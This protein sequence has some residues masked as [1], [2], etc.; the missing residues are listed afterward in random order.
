[1]RFEGRGSDEL[2]SGGIK[3][4]NFAVYKIKTIKIMLLEFHNGKFNITDIKFGEHLIEASN[5]TILYYGILSR[6]VTEKQLKDALTSNPN[7]KSLEDFFN[8][9]YF[10]NN[11]TN[12]AA[13]P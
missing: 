12:N 8:N 2:E 3:K 9:G 11:I 13:M 7:T 5:F 1:M 4:L 6:N 10:V